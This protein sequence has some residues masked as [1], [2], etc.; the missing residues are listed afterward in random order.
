MISTELLADIRRLYYAEHWKIGTIATELGLHH[1]TVSRALDTNRF[2]RGSARTTKLAPFEEFVQ[3]TL[4][5]YPLGW[6][7]FSRPKPA[8]AKVEP[9]RLKA[10]LSPS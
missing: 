6:T 1:D 2:R 8:S 4:G 5:K 10:L 7:P 9:A 3:Q